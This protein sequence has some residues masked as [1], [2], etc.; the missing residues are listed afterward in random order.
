MSSPETELE[1]I[2]R[3]PACPADACIIWLH[4]LGA[5][6]SDFV[7]IIEQLNLPAGMSLRFIF[8][9]APLRPITINQG[10]RMPGWY[11]IYGMDIVSREDVAGIEQS[12]RALDALIAQ[13][14]E[15]GIAAHRILLAGFSQG[16][17]VALHCGL[18]QADI[19]LGGIIALSTYLPGCTPFR[20][21]H[22]LPVFFGH[23]RDDT[24]VALRFGKQSSQRLEHAGYH[25]EWH[26][27]AM[28]HSVCMEEIDDI[29]HW[30]CA[31]LGD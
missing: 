16:G 28:Q 21:G 5:D 1:C 12:S 15:Q 9:N 26:E 19:Q 7:P 23:G 3:D 8:P 31:C 22:A 18:K 25:P 4:G 11:D 14:I 24:V 29:R 27:Y 6:G 2:V 20:A 30:L 13:Q 17:A 10:Y